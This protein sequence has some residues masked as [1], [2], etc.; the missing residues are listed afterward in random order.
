MRRH[1]SV[2]N[3]EEGGCGGSGLVLSAVVRPAGVPPLPL[4]ALRLMVPPLRLVSAAI[5]Q[6]IQQSHVMDYGMLEE[7]VTMVTD[8]VP[9][10]LNDSQRAQLILGL[11]ARLVLEL[12]RSKPFTDLQTIQPHLDRIKTLTPLWGTQA[13]AEVGLS[14]SSFLGL[15]Q[16]LLKDPDE[17]EHFFQDVFPVEFGSSYDAAIQKLMWQFL[18]RLEKLL[19]VSNFQQAALLLSDSPS[20]LEECVQSVSHPQQLKTLLQYHRDLG[21]LD[22]HDTLSS[23]DGDCILS[24]LCLPPVERVVIATEQTDSETHVS[25]L[26]V[27]MDT[28]TKELEVDSAT[29]AKYTEMEPGTNMD[30]IAEDRVECKRKEKASSVI[31][32]EEEDN[33]EFAETEEVEPAYETVLVLGEDGKMAPLV[34]TNKFKGLK[35]DRNDTSGMPDGKKH[36]TPSPPQ[37]KSIDLSDTIISSMLHKPS[38]E[39]QRIDTANLTLPLEPVRRNRGRKMKTL[40]ARELKQTKTEFSEQ[41]KRVCKRVKTP[42]NPNM[43]TVCGRVLSRFSDM[44]KHMQ[45]HKNGRT[46]QCRNCQKTFKHL[47]TLQTHRKSCLF[48]TGQQEEIPSVEGSSVPFTMCE[49]EFAQ[50]SIDRRTCKV[51]GKIVHRIGYLSTHMKIHSANRHYS[52]G[53]AKA[54]Q[55]ASPEGEDTEPS[56]GVTIEATP[57]DSDS[58]STSTPQDP[59]YDPEL[60]QI[61]R[62]KCSSTAKKSNRK[63]FQKPKHM[64]RICGKYVTAGAFEYHMRTHS[65]ERPFSCPHPQCGMKFI[66]SGGL[67]VHLRRY[68]K[69]RTVDAAELDSFNIRFECDKCEKTFTIQSKLRKHKLIHGP[70]YCTGCRK[71]LPDLETL[72]RHKL[73][74]RPVQCSMCEESFMLTNLRTHYLDVHKFSG[75]FVCTHCPKSYK[76]FHSLIKHEMVHTGNLPLQCSQCPKRFIYN[77][78]LVEH[79]KRHSDDRPCLC[80]ECGKAFCTNID[81]KQH[82]QNSHGEKSTECRFPCRHCGKPFRLSNSRANHEKTKHGG[83]RYPCTYCGKQFVCANALKRHDLIHTGERPFKCNHKSCDKAFRSRAELRIHTRYHTGERPFKCNVCGKGFVQANYLTTHYRTHTG[84][85]PYSCSVCDKSFNY[86]DSLKRHMSTHSNEKPYKCLDCGKAFERK[87]LLNVHKRSCTSLLKC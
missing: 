55:K 47:Y 14:E 7:F 75:P 35:R 43:C 74:H 1:V 61:K 72:T 48:G 22:N 5:W 71:V 45:T 36:R 59:S 56:S 46:Y 33:S 26:N 62:P 58:S 44:K 82:M 64:C 25:S 19:P 13:D 2:K 83:V 87:T 50:S 49:A 16:T 76:K 30:V 23:S 20:L 6:T 18:S 57:E 81:L 10:L 85:K 53:E 28:F 41:K 54:V 38:V 32:D 80:W 37:M 9:E 52:L 8:V 17:R 39:L 67:R 79:E 4:P 34:K 70:L 15:V 63:T 77:Y 84:E 60:S 65:G 31:N 3:G 68:C 66:H 12:C 40:L 21:Q 69:V 86:H 24:A 73:W 11:R 51:C 42:Q 27:F 78:D 29:L